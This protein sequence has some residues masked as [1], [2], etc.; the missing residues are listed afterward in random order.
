MTGVNI[1]LPL[2]FLPLPGEPNV[3][4]DEWIES[5]EFFLTARGGD[6]SD[7]QKVAPLMCCIGAEGQAQYRAV[8]DQVVDPP[9]MMMSEYERAVARLS[10]RFADRGG[11]M[12]ARLKF[13]QRSQLP[14]ESIVEFVAALR[15]LVQKCKFGSYGPSDAVKEQLIMGVASE[16]VRGTMLLQPEE[17]TLEQAIGTASRAERSQIEAKELTSPTVN[18]RVQQPRGSDQRSQ[19]CRNCTK[20]AH[21]SPEE[22]SARFSKCFRCGKIGHFARACSMGRKFPSK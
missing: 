15:K 21:S 5:F 1:P 16:K 3:A 7:D 6:P 4:F 11:I 22:C 13:R 18:A 9:Y 14:G 8:R 2:A 10:Q 19:W 17:T 12:S 20:T